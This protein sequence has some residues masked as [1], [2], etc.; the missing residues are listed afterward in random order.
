MKTLAIDDLLTETPVFTPN[1]PEDKYN[2]SQISQ[3]RYTLEEETKN[4][5]DEKAISD[6]DISYL[7]DSLISTL[8]ILDQSWTNSFNYPARVSKIVADKVIVDCLIDKPNQIFEKRI[9]PKTVFTSDVV[10]GSF[11]LIRIF[12]GKNEFRIKI[13][14]DRYVNRSDFEFT[15]YIDKLENLSIFKK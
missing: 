13:E 5:K 11:F 6:D 1:K 12:E 15:G 8:S 9:F 7:H 2:I 10:A 3:R 14:D 4:L